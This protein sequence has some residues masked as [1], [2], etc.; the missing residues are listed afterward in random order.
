MLGWRELATAT[1]DV[2]NGLPADERARAMIIATNYG[3]AGALELYGRNLGL[4]RPVSRNGDFYHWGLGD[5]PGDVA[6]VV[7]GSVEALGQFFGSVTLVRTVENPLGVEEERSVP[8][9]VCR[10]PRRPL[11]EVWAELGPEWG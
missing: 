5:R 10:E 9:F 4:P 7:G 1:R 3:R 2:V 6:V 8:I 11:R